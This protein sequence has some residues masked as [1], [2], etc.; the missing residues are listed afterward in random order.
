MKKRYGTLLSLVAL[1]AAPMVAQAHPG[2]GPYSFAGGFLHPFTGVDHLLAMLAVGMWSARLGGHARWSMPLMFVAM[3]AV[4]AGAAVSGVSLPL[5]E[6]GIAASLVVFGL[7]LSFSRPLGLKSSLALVGLFAV[8]HGYA[9]GQ[10]MPESA[11]G[12]LFGCGFILASLSLQ[13]TGLWIGLR[14]SGKNGLLRV[15]GASIAGAGVLLL[16]GA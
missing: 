9:H 10:E 7:A 11:S 6:S 5:V 4:G 2:H 16:I 8:F 3:L 15:V 12:L 14:A 1:L 13:A